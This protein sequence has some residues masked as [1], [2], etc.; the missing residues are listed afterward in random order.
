MSSR[1]TRAE[2]TEFGGV[3]I[4][5]A[6]GAGGVVTLE[7]EVGAVPTGSASGEIQV[8]ANQA[9]EQVGSAT[10]SITQTE[11][12]AVYEVFLPVSPREGFEAAGAFVTVQLREDGQTVDTADTQVELNPK[13][14][15]PEDAPSDGDVLG[16]DPAVLALVGGGAAAYFLLRRRGQSGTAQGGNTLL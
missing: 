14:D 4:L 3:S 8:V 13:Q 7:L 10:E 15:P 12:R 16:V 2:Q 6:E 1:S 5:S 11:N 9:G